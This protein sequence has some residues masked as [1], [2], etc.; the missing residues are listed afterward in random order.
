MGVSAKVIFVCLINHFLNSALLWR[1]KS[2]RDFASCFIIMF[3]RWFL[4]SWLFSEF[5]SNQWNFHCFHY[6]F[7]LYSVLL[8]WLINDFS[9]VPITHTFFNKSAWLIIVFSKI[10]SSREDRT[11][12]ENRTKRL[13]FAHLRT[14]N[15]VF[16]SQMI[17]VHNMWQGVLEKLWTR[18]PPNDSASRNISS[19]QQDIYEQQISVVP[20]VAKLQTEISQRPALE[21]SRMRCSNKNNTL[22]THLISWYHKH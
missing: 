14:T 7:V 5:C 17:Y 6:T 19:Q 12:I 21:D 11:R 1:K 15:D 3:Y 22:R 20:N 8:F 16:S 2:Q 9:T 18:S 13:S 4:F 10:L